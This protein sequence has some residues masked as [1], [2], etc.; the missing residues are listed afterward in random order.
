VTQADAEDHGEKYPERE[1]AVEE[2]EVLALEWRAA[3]AYGL[4]HG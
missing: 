4:R 3:A 2:G 1:E